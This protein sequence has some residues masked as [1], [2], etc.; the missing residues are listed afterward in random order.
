MNLLSVMNHPSFGRA[1]AWVEQHRLGAAPSRW[2]PDGLARLDDTWFAEHPTRGARRPPTAAFEGLP[3]E[4][5][6][7]ARAACGITPPL[8][9]RLPPSLCEVCARW[10]WS[11]L[12][13]LP[14]E[15][16]DE[17]ALLDEIQES[18]DP[19][20]ALAAALPRL[21]PNTLVHAVNLAGLDDLGGIL[22]RAA[23]RTAATICGRLP[24]HWRQRVWHARTA[25]ATPGHT[26]LAE[27]TTLTRSGD[28]TEVLFSLGA[29]RF[30]TLLGPH[31]LA[32]RQTAQ[33]LP[34]PAARHLL[35]AIAPAGSSFE[36]APLLTAL[37]QATSIDR[38][39]A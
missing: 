9:I 29:S 20:D 27:L 34:M 38:E 22:A 15:T 3:E 28:P 18:A 6:A 21:S 8:R 16:Q 31:P 25:G 36:S 13:D 33:L 2:L 5:A 12:V 35:G 19:R 23:D 10:C 32:R 24:P 26:A 14:S 37:R 11:D 17:P 7:R 4:Q 30:S 1:L 39:G